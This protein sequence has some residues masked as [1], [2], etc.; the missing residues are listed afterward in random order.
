MKTPLLFVILLFL[1]VVQA[2]SQE[3]SRKPMPLFV[4]HLPSENKALLRRKAAPRHNIFNK[5]LCFKRVCRGFVGW[6]TR[7]RKTRFKGYKNKGALPAPKQKTSP[8]PQTP[9]QKT[10]TVVVAAPQPIAEDTAPARE[11]VFILDEVLFERNSA[12]LNDKFTF[13][14]DSLVELLQS[15]KHLTVR[16][17]GHT[18]NTGSEA[19]NLKLSANRAQAVAEYLVGSNIAESRIT[20]EGFGSSK[21]IAPNDTE[22]GRAKNRRVEIAISD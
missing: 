10:D 14:L 3:T 22:R 7:Q 6:R 8:V 20:F 21:P 2:R 4:S 11:Q 1:L 17:S 9:L 19:H 18:D 5:V 13:R 16:I 12:N 15:G